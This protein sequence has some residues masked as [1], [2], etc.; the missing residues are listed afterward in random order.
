LKSILKNLDLEVTAPGEII[1]D[2]RKAY[3][4]AGHAVAMIRYGGKILT[5]TINPDEKYEA[6]LRVSKEIRDPVDLLTRL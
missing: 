6:R 3:H 4:E 5:V 2:Q 1:E